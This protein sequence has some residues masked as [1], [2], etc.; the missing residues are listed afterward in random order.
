MSSATA[1]RWFAPSHE[2]YASL[3][4]YA[5]VKVQSAYVRQA[6]IHPDHGSNRVGFREPSFSDI[7]SSLRLNPCYPFATE[8]QLVYADVDEENPKHKEDVYGRIAKE[9]PLDAESESESVKSAR[10]HLIEHLATE[11]FK[12]E[13]GNPTENDDNDKDVS[14]A[15]HRLSRTKAMFT[16]MLQ[17][18]V[19]DDAVIEYIL[20]A[21]E[22][23]TAKRDLLNI[24]SSQTRHRSHRPVLVLVDLI[25]DMQSSEV[26]VTTGWVI[27]YEFV[28]NLLIIKPFLSTPDRHPLGGSW[29]DS[30]PDDGIS[31]FGSPATFVEKY[32]YNTTQGA[33]DDDVADADADQTPPATATSASPF[34]PHH[35]FQPLIHTIAAKWIHRLWDSLFSS[36]SSS[37]SF[38]SS[39]PFSPPNHTNF[40]TAITSNLKK[41]TTIPFPIQPKINNNNPLSFSP[42]PSSSSSSSLSSIT[43][44]VTAPESSTPPPPPSSTSPGPSSTR[45]QNQKRIYHFDTYVQ[46]QHLLES[47]EADLRAV[48]RRAKLAGDE[49]VAYQAARVW[50]EVLGLVRGVG[51]V[52]GDEKGKGKGE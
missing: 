10:K 52:N 47:E 38:P 45:K 27:G 22:T 17:D 12:S 9:V 25:D 5:I 32:Y 11:W 41:L 30:L 26:G 7:L 4:D 43:S 13:S 2:F 42:S 51:L 33:V 49:D 40:Q 6:R 31:F 14:E 18:G 16:G 39:P 1:S 46:I 21:A 20:G 36:S 35:G 8:G 34:P 3:D 29:Y 23:E 48:A 24:V 44:T 19:I 28:E 37:S 50:E 15:H